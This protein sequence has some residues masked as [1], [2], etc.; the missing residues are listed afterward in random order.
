V[1]VVPARDHAIFTL[2]RLPDDE[3]GRRRAE[4]LLPCC[5]ASSAAAG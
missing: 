2:A 5:T 1:F 3:P 4:D